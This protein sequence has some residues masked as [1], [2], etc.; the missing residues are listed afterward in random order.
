MKKN[1]KIIL[2]AEACLVA[3]A[4]FGCVYGPP[5]DIDIF[6]DPPKSTASTTEYKPDIDEMQCVYGPPVAYN[7]EETAE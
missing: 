1:K 7:T 6:T 5:P 3:F 4:S 2:G